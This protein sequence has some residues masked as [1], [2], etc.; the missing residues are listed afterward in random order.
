M[1]AA[2]PFNITLSI[3]VITLYFGLAEFRD[4]SMDIRDDAFREDIICHRI[5]CA[6]KRKP[7]RQYRM[8]DILNRSDD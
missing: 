8:P 1:R 7:N 5:G 6:K 2:L 3:Q 4:V